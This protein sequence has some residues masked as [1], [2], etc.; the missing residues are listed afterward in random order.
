MRRC[1]A[2][3]NSKIS[4]ATRSVTPPL[5]SAQARKMFSVVV[6]A[7]SPVTLTYDE[8]GPNIVEGLGRR[9]AAIVMDNADPNEPLRCE[10]YKPEQ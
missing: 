3:L 1:F 9:E 2:V 10:S 8:G 5:K 6:I 7:P 4:N